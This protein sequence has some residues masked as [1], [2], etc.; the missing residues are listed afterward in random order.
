MSVRRTYRGDTR[1]K[2]IAIYTS[3]RGRVYLLWLIGIVISVAKL[4]PSSISAGGVTFSIERPEVIQGALYV[5]CL[6]IW[7]DT[8]LNII[9]AKRLIGSGEK[10]DAIFVALG[11]F[12]HSFK[13]RTLLQLKDVRKVARQ[14]LTLTMAVSL[15][16]IS[17]PSLHSSVR[18]ASNLATRAGDG[19]MDVGSLT[20]NLPSAMVLGRIAVLRQPLPGLIQF[21]AAEQAINLGIVP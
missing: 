18:I 21:F 10:R 12:R 3:R 17:I 20:A 2:W 5:I 13:N 16:E 1:E 9:V 19:W 7:L 11:R 8:V 4:R 14:Q 6:L 15:F